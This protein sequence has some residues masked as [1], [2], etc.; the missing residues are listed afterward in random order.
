MAKSF[1]FPLKTLF[2]LLCALTLQA[3]LPGTVRADDLT[4]ALYGERW[5]RLV[6]P[7]RPNVVLSAQEGKTGMPQTAVRDYASVAQLWCL[8][9]QKGRYRLQNRL[10]GG[11]YALTVTRQGKTPVGVAFVPSANAQLWTLQTLSNEKGVVTMSLVAYPSKKEY[12]ALGH[13]DKAG[14]GA[15]LCTQASDGAAQWI[16]E[17]ASRQIDLTAVV[18][19]SALPLQLQDQVAEIALS[20]DGESGTVPALKRSIL[21]QELGQTAT[22]YFPLTKA[23]TAQCVSPCRGYAF[24]SWAPGY[25]TPVTGTSITLAAGQTEPALKLTLRTAPAEGAVSVFRTYD[26]HRVPYRIPSLASTHR[27]GLIAVCD[28]RYCFSDIGFGRVDLVMKSSR[29]GGA[30]W[31]KDTVVLRGGGK[32][33]LTGFGDPCLVA[34]RTSDKALLVCVAG[35]VPYGRSTV[36]NP[37]HIMRC[38]GTYN[39]QTLSWEWG[40]AE[41]MTGMFYKN[42]FKER[43]NGLFMSSGRILQSRKVKINKYY[44]LYAAL[45]THKGNFVVFSDDFGTNWQVLGSAD[46]SCVPKGDEAKCEELPDGSV[47]I[48]SRRSGG[49]WWNIYRFNNPLTATGQ[50]GEP[51]DSRTVEGGI[52]NT[53]NPCNGEILLVRALEKESGTPLWLALQSLP[54]GPERH[55]VTIYYKPLAA[56]TDYDSPLHLAQN[57][58]T[59][60]LVSPRGSAYSTME[61]LPD[62][63]IGIFFEE[64]PEYFQMIY[65]PLSLETITGGR[66]TAV[67]TAASAQRVK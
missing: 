36:A 35:D 47:L 28:R 45:C 34:D 12:N 41:D 26:A 66:Y 56:K 9:G 50:W 33:L 57:W 65:Q 15:T 22:Y 63:R 54:A 53:S 20:V 40:K 29:D 16:V 17:N 3:V 10:M 18:A 14:L 38:T 4:G 25:R 13:A 27:G 60:H 21:R 58:Q 6:H 44:R 2:L 55:N 43:I 19:D 37:Q 59:G 51:V 52:S 62:G 49:R 1:S 64:E 48:S 32:G 5:V 7:S 61:A 24:E 39:T 23:V 46:T 31:G 8:T 67:S 42:L 30:T 11:S